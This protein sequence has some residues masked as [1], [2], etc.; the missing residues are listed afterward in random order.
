[1]KT[2]KQFPRQM[3]LGELH[4]VDRW[5]DLRIYGKGIKIG[6][7]LVNFGKLENS[8]YLDSVQ[9]TKKLALV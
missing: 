6:F 1:M 8:H 4:K 9:T 5:S 7:V 2:P 3:K